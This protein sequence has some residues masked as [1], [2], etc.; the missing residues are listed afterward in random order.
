VKRPVSGVLAV[1]Q[2]NATGGVSFREQQLNHSIADRNG[3]SLA[4]YIHAIFGFIRQVKCRE[5]LV[6]GCGGGTLATM[7][8]RAG[9]KVV[10]ADT[11]MRAF[12]IARRY[13][14]MPEGIE[15]HVEDGDAFLRRQA[16]RY[17][18]IVLDAYA[19]GKIPRHLTTR[20]FFALAKSRLR[21]RKSLFLVNLLVAD[22]DDRAPDRVAWRLSAVWRQVRLL[23]AEGRD[24]RNAVAV[25]GSVRPLKRP[26]L[27]MRPK[28]GAPKLARHIGALDFRPL[29]P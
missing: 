29:R 22:D 26:R 7:L 18:A 24:D 1:E 5:V 12:E 2:N 9:V 21:L 28:A 4:D 19:E 11:D 23:D 15:C 10:I 3:V 14:H 6:I 13:F 27:L 16:R 20:R 17:D 8:H 25:A